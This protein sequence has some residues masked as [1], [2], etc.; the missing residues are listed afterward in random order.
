VTVLFT[1]LV[2]STALM[3]RFGAERAEELR[4]E[5][6]ELTRDV[7][8]STEG[9][10]VKNLG[11]GLMVVFNG[12]TAALGCAVEIQQSFEERN[13]GNPEPLSLRIGIATGEADVVEEDYFGVPVVEA[14]RLCAHAGGGEVL[15]TNFVRILVGSRGGFNFE[16]MGALELKGLEVPVDV[17]RMSWLARIG[18]RSVPLPS[19]LGPT[20]P[21]G[22][23]GRV[24]ER[25]RLTKAL[26][27]VVAGE[28]R[29]V[30][31]GGEP[32][33]GKT[34]LAAEFAREAFAQGAIV[35]YG[36]CDEDLGVPYQPWIEALTFLGQY[37]PEEILEA[38]VDARGAE[39]APLAR[40][41]GRPTKGKSFSSSD[42]GSDR[43][44]L[45]SAAVDLLAR[46]SSV[47]PIVMVIDDLHWA[48]RPTLQ[49]LEYVV[50]ADPGLRLLIVG[51]FRDS[52][53]GSDHPLAD[54]LASLHRE[55]GVERLV[56]RGLGDVDLLHLME[57]MAGH[58]MPS[59]GLALR[60]ALLVETA[61][62][63]FFV[64]EIL[65][66]LAETRAIYQDESGRWVANADLRV[67]GLPVSIREVVSRRVARMG[68]DAVRILSMAAVIGRDF[69]IATLSE[70]TD[71]DADT[72]VDICDNAVSAALL[73]EVQDGHGY[74]FAHALIEHTL[75]DG[76]SRPRRARAHR[77]VAE[78]LEELFGSDPGERI[79][80]LAYHWALA[81]QPLVA[82]K[83]I[84]YAK[85]A[86]DR[87][88]AQ[89]APDEAIRWYLQALDLEAQESEP[90]PETNLDLRIGL[91]VAQRQSGVAAYRETLLDAAH[92]AIELGD[93]ERLAEV[94]LANQRGFSTLFVVDEERVQ[95]LETVLELVPDGRPDKV[96]LLAT[97][98][99][100]L[101]FDG[102]AQGRES[103]VDSAISLAQ[104][105]PDHATAARALTSLMAGMNVPALTKRAKGVSTEAIRRAEA[106]ND[107]VILYWA[108]SGRVH[109]ATRTGQMEERK[110]SLSILDSLVTKINQPTVVWDYH[111]IQAL[112]NLLIGDSDQAEI[113][114]TQ[115]VEIGMAS[116]QPD[117]AVLFGTQIMTTHWQ[118]GTSTDLIPL[119]ADA[120]TENP[121]TPVFAACLTLTLAEGGRYD[122]A[123]RRLQQFA[124]DGF[125]FPM[126]AAWITGMCCYA[127]AA[128]ILKALEVSRA[129]FDILAPWRDLVL[130]EYATVGNHVSHYLGC[131]AALLERYD[132][133]DNFFSQSCQFNKDAGA[134]FLSTRTNLEWAKA[135]MARNEASDVVHARTLL[136]ASYV[137]ASAHGY[138]YVAK[139]AERLIET[140]DLSN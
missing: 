135:L 82:T 93:T 117:A 12:A 128:V 81:T 17:W 130:F 79:G 49:L 116:G 80:A 18:E 77:A 25:E 52:E 111:L 30:L 139:K 6:F 132:E 3:S 85:K 138:A 137:E 15:I 102:R 33:I 115:A 107:P 9:R 31:L 126:N 21:L 92:R 68:V 61:G 45:F 16:S 22:F 122:E 1:D 140:F 133:A 28:R 29:V 95:I 114:A 125:G 35:L 50:S 43:H 103:L 121:D 34:S 120:V 7:V 129:L 66:H 98:L 87:A 59:D 32:G 42:D 26:K 10:E 127:E 5:Q 44:S 101:S 97:L 39:L 48:D 123:M 100:E 65:R 72:L 74:A 131:L 134:R 109:V 54:V 41:L 11:D 4:R 105:T 106:A 113:E 78:A 73:V 2:G 75:Y 119:L 14:A 118:R 108:H 47:S 90:D 67:T 94:A 89:L 53:I 110:A 23:V 88:I 8:S 69:D 91:G 24:N 55:P 64:S 36:R 76:L 37:G 58:K 96:L 60:D 62:N 70:A 104:S 51:S 124:D 112:H 57:N 99:T 71:V 46:M 56:L 63:P 27:D 40:N 84:K 19:R 83:A 86:G 38:H 136:D 13:R 20:A